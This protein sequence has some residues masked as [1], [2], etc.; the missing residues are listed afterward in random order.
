MGQRDVH[1]EPPPQDRAMTKPEITVSV[2]VVRSLVEAVEVHAGVSRVRLL[3]AA[4][5]DLTRL[6]PTDARVRLSEV[7]ALC[8]LAMDAARDPALGLHWA[9]RLG[10]ATFV[11]VSH[12]LAH[13][14]TLRQALAALGQFHRLL[15]DEPSYALLEDEHTFTLRALRMGAKSPR[16]RCFTA[17]M[18][19]VGFCRLV[20]SF[21]FHARPE[22]VSFDY[23]APAHHAEYARVLGDVV[24][25]E[26]PCTEIVFRRALLDAP[27]PHQDADVHEA[28]SALAERRLL[29]MTQ[30]TPYAVRVRDFLVREG[31]RQQADMNAAARSLGLSVRSLRRR[32]A[33]EGKPYNDI[34]SEA[35]GSVAKQFLHDQRRT[36]QETAFEMGFADASTFHRAFKR[37]TGTTPSAARGVLPRADKRNG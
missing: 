36:I 23:P 7:H 13:A 14:A 18:I 8:D 31:W 29:R 9:E 34:L 26:K 20:R 15:C 5:L 30:G 28:L 33:E 37:W 6:E 25:F 1:T 4:K 22:R 10:E 16:V 2:Q 32:L 21:D 17:E 3:A 12:L 35:L 27:A 24:Q 19:M 11:P